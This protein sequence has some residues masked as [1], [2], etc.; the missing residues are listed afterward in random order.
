MSTPSSSFAHQ[1]CRARVVH[2]KSAYRTQSPCVRSHCSEC[3]PTAT[4]TATTTSNKII[5]GHSLPVRS[6]RMRNV[7][8]AQN[9]IVKCQRIANKLKKKTIRALA[10]SQYLR[11]VNRKTK[12]KTFRRIC[13][14]VRIKLPRF[15]LKLILLLLLCSFS[16]LPLVFRRILGQT[17]VRDKQMKRPKNS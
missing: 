8:R 17:R 7:G 16:L 14:C 15:N 10:N 2:L 9:A 6:T 12:K 3:I 13:D 1:R 4:M 11:A 5:E